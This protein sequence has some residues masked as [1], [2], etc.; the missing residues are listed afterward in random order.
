MPKSELFIVKVLV[1]IFK[2]N[3]RINTKSR[4]Q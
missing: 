1:N 3:Y 4:K 2:V